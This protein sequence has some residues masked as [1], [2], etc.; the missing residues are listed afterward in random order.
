MNN[1][2]VYFAAQGADRR[3]LLL[4][5]ELVKYGYKITLISSAKRPIWRISSEFCDGVFV[6]SLPRIKKVYDHYGYIL[7]TMLMPPFTLK[8]AQIAHFFNPAQ[9][10]VAL[11]AFMTKILNKF[12][13]RRRSIIVDWDDQWGR[14]GLSIYHGFVVHGI[15][16]ALEEKTPFWG[17]ALTVTTKTLKKRALKLGIDKERIVWIPHGPSIDDKEIISKSH[18][19]R[20]LGIPR[21]TVVLLY[22]GK[23]TTQFL[24]RLVIESFSKICS[25]YSDVILILLGWISP[26]RSLG[27]T[28]NVK[29]QTIKTWAPESLLPIYLSAADIFLMPMENNIFEKSRLPLRLCD[30]MAAGRPIIASPV[31]EVNK[32]IKQ[33]EIGIV[34]HQNSVDAFVEC[35]EKLICDKKLAQTLGRRGKKAAMEVFSWKKSAKLLNSL[36][37]TLQD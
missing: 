37:L 7:R 35:I 4:A 13:A 17:D 12:K 19:R 25:C 2:L 16:T 26:L 27:I 5:K 1:K 8:E 28:N 18:A 30:Y 32:I 3:A 29:K 22:M 24:E 10:S 11:S 20:I 31:G 9:P 14:G 36:Y 15:M 21:S 34:P 33:Y 6:I 23:F